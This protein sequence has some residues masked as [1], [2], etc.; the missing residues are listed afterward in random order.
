ML[1]IRVTVDNDKVVIEGLNRLGNRLQP[2]VSR[3]LSKAVKGVYSKAHDFLNGPGAK[4]SNI[5]GGGWPVPVR[6]GHLRRSLHWIDP[7]SSIMSG[8]PFNMTFSAGPLEAMVI[9]TA[10]YA[11][12]IHEG[13]GTSITHGPRPYITRAFESFNTG[14]RLT[15]IVQA[16]ITKEIEKR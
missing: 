1:N 14:E 4:D 12:V 6:T 10:S 13:K 5:P 2:A 7:G 9:N 15:Q 8:E 11:M 16:E 3:G